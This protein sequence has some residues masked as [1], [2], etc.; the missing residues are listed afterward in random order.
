MHSVQIGEDK[1]FFSSSPMSD[2][3]RL[4]GAKRATFED[5][6]IRQEKHVVKTRESTG[7]LNGYLN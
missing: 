2:L 4:L 3:A 6:K 5:L 7:L 1:T